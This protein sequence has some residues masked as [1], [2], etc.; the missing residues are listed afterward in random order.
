MFVL[1]SKQDS[2]LISLLAFLHLN[3]GLFC[4]ELP[5]PVAASA[6]D[7]SQPYAGT[8]KVVTD[9]LPGNTGHG[10]RFLRFGP[11]GLLVLGIGAPCNV[12]ELETTSGGIQY[13]T[14]YSLNVTSGKLSKIATGMLLTILCT[15]RNCVQVVIRSMSE[16]SMKFVVLHSDSVLPTVSWNSHNMLSSGWF[17]VTK[18]VKL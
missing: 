9:Q 3:N 8:R 4:T 12:C 11:D 18:Q 17:S 14:L 10:L 16:D 1:N 13:G 5:P 2:P 6:A 15:G 7:C